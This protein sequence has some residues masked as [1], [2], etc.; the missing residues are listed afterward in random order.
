MDGGMSIQGIVGTELFP[1]LGGSRAP[2]N[3]KHLICCITV[4]F[5]SL[6]VGHLPR[7]LTSLKRAAVLWFRGRVPKLGMYRTSLRR[8]MHKPAMLTS[9]T[10]AWNDRDG[11]VCMC[12]RRGIVSTYPSPTHTHV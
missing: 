9:V 3:Q 11:S 6:L 12:V 4:S 7:S 1:V 10:V 8:H 5:G 2:Q